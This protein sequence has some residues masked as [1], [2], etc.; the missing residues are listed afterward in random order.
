LVSRIRNQYIN[1]ILIK[2]ERNGIDAAKLKQLIVQKID[3]IRGV[4]EFKSVTI[5]V[6]VD[7]M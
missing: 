5:V 3:W 6:D 7:P 1:T 2:F 4:K